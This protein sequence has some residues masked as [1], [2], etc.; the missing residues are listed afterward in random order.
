MHHPSPRLI[1]ALLASALALPAQTTINYSDGL[2][3]AAS[4]DTSAP[5]SPTYLY[6]PSGAATQSGVI[7]GTGEINVSG[8]QLTLAGLNT[9]TG[10][11]R[12]ATGTLV[13]TN[14]SSLGFGPLSFAVGTLRNSTDL[15]L[16][17][18]V[19][20][21]GNTNFD[22]GAGFLTLDG[23]VSGSGSLHK[24]GTNL[25]TLNG[26]QTYTG[27]TTVSGGQIKFNGSTATASIT[28]YGPA[29]T[30]YFT[31][32]QTYAGDITGA[33]ILAREFSGTTILTGSATHV[34][35]TLVNTGTLQI[36]AGGTTGS[37]SGDV[38]LGQGGT[39][40]VHRSGTT[41][42]PVNIQG[43][44]ALNVFGPGTTILTGTASHT[45]GT[46]VDAGTLQ[47]GAPNEGGALSGNVTLS[48]GATLSFSRNTD[49]SFSG[50]VSGDG[51]VTVLNSGFGG[52][53]LLL[54][55]N[56]THTGGTAVS[57]PFFGG[58][59]SYESTTLALGSPGALGTAGTIS[60]GSGFN[61]GRLQ[62]SAANTTDY[63]SRFS[64]AENQNYGIDT[65]GQDVTFASAFGAAGGSLD[66]YGPGTL[67]L[68]GENT[69]TGDT[70]VSG[71]IV[72]IGDG[73]STGS[74][75]GD[76]NLSSRIIYST[77]HLVVNRSGEST[78]SNRILGEG[79]FTKAGPGTVTLTGAN[80]YTGGTILSGGT[81]ALGSAGAIGTTGEI[82]F[83]G[84]TL[85]FSAANTTDYSPR[86]ADSY[87]NPSAGIQHVRIDTNGQDVVFASNSIYLTGSLTKLGAGTLTLSGNAY[88]Y[89]PTTIAAG[90]LQIGNGGTAGYLGPNIVNEGAL[91]FNPSHD[92]SF[93][94]ELSGS[95]SLTKLGTGTL[96]IAG[97]NTYTGPTTVSAGTLL[98]Y[99]DGTLGATPVTLSP[100]T[101]LYVNGTALP[102]FAL[103][104]GLAGSGTVA[105]S[106]K[107]VVVSTAFTPGTL[108][109]NGNLA[110]AANTATTFVAAATPAATSAVNVTGTLALQGNLAIT[111]AAGFAFASGQNIT[112]ATA[113]AGITPGLA[114]VTVNGVA[115]AESSPDVWSA[116]I[117]GLGYTFTEST[118]TLA[119]A[120]APISPLQAWRDLY[121]PS[122][123]NDGTG[124]GAYSADPDGDGLAN[125]VEYATHTSPVAANFSPVAAGLQSGHLTLTFPRIDDPALRYTVEGR[126]DLTSGSWTTL[127]PLAANNPTFGFA[128]SIADQTETLSETVIDP[129]ALTTRP[130]RFLRLSIDLVP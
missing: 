91:V 103:A 15:I 1:A 31:S 19:V 38:T 95:G 7:S 48:H 74:V 115:L 113:A 34:G 109:V 75:K 10:G 93:L 116:N 68:T 63:S 4:I 110:L 69:Y 20:L 64:S 22:V 27:D 85:R 129:V 46:L 65:N 117:A 53:T 36:G 57:G 23:T 102:N 33:G 13:L 81:L 82:S 112:F 97:P 77:G 51:A 54:N 94:G 73:G 42:F 12:L 119:V 123:G 130:K 90:T 87:S 24:T 125:L 50:N 26:A 66:K 16:A 108:V 101:T 83:S 70:R 88:F 127:V 9:H 18:N 6:V 84:G 105:A 80:S 79:S 72:Q 21:L 59:F 62:F 37:L 67:T 39:L 89:G 121:F 43:N 71:G 25:L 128:G 122:A 11:T 52:R 118:A 44:G 49:S 99:D 92:V 107:T 126:D 5:N 14:T 28:L 40:A 104:A 3:R 2:V 61:S 60:F 47:V 124:I 76:V 114:G 35:G 58:G 29:T 96:S 32:S 98:L 86:F 30:V 55:G 78:F 8:G 120:T 106:N 45:G 41:D 111:K 17:N 56:N 100:G